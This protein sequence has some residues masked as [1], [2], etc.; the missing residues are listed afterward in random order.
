MGAKITAVFVRLWRSSNPTPPETKRAE[1]RRQGGN[2]Y[3]AFTLALGH[4]LAKGPT[5]RQEISRI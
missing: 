5:V 4:R 1:F 2:Q 3:D